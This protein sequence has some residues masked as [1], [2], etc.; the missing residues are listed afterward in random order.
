LR[1]GETRV[2]GEKYL[3]AE[4][5]T[6][7]KLNP[8]IAWLRESNLGHIGGRL[9]LSPLCNPSSPAVLR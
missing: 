4:K 8:H 6:N 9:A 1:R 2:P 7:N 5:R 3:R